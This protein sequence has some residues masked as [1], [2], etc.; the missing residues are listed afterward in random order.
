MENTFH[1]MHVELAALADREFKAPKNHPHNLTRKEHNALNKFTKT[2]SLVFKKGDKTTCTVV[3]TRKEYV[4]EGMTHLSD[5]RTY[6][7]LNR[8]Y[9]PDVVEHIK[10]T[11]HQYKKGGLLSDHMVR[12]CMPNT[13]CRTAL[14][15]FKKEK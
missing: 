15:Y 5:A 8:D 13:E 14:L 11:L 12:Q 7:R 2:S 3:K 10:Y 1:A 9:T 6:M 4:R